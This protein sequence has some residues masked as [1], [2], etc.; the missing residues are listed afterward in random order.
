MSKFIR[1]GRCTCASETASH[2]LDKAVSLRLV[3][4]V[5]GCEN[6]QMLKSLID[7]RCNV[8]VCSKS[9]NLTPL[10]LSVYW[11][12]EEQVDLLIEQ[13]VDVNCKCLQ[14]K[15]SALSRAASYK[16][17]DVVRK[18]LK[19]KDI[20]VNIGNSRN[21]TPLILSLSADCKEILEML[22]EAGADVNVKDAR[23]KTPTMLAAA[24]SVDFLQPIIAINPDIN[25]KDARYETALFHAVSVSKYCVCPCNDLI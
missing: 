21:E 6:L 13:N 14:D 4:V 19:V 5:A 11:N 8:S 2:L 9:L 16:M 3:H 23:E 18:L 22:L 24:K 12:K 15:V 10:F 1:L 20:D 17:K 7:L 25:S